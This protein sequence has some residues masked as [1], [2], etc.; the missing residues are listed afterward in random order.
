LESKVFTFTTPE[1]DQDV[2]SCVIF[3]DIHE[4]IPLFDSLLA[5]ANQQ[6]YEF[7]IFN[8]DVMNHIDKESHLVDRALR[9]FAESLASTIPNVYTRGNHDVRDRYARHL[10]EYFASPDDSNFYSF[11]YGPIHFIVMDLGE[12]KPGDNKEYSGFVNFGP[13]REAQRVWL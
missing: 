2:V 6:P 12:D 3:N 8:G 9:P 5:I 10:N 11:D 7:V 1:R 13:F 4:N